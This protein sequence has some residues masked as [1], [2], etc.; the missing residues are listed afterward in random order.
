MNKTLLE[1]FTDKPL[2]DRIQ[3]RLPKLFRIAELESSRA[4]KIGMQVGSLRE[5]VIV[6]LLIYKFGEENVNTDFSI[7]EPEIDVEIFGQPVSIKTITGRSFGGVKLIW[8]VDAP[9]AREFLTGYYPRYDILLI[10][11]DWGRK[12][13]F[14]YIPVEAQ[15]KLFKDIGREKYVKLPKPGTNPRG[16]EIS[17]EALVSL[18][19]DKETKVIEVGWQKSEIDY[20]P[21]QRW[22]DYWSEV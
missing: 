18:I 8:T 22:V 12:G 4:G 10:Q 16:V 5:N 6:A 21:Y 7:V 3:K 19:Q 1:V 11:I 9:K 15:E 17:K 14:Y 2:I 13:G 20:R